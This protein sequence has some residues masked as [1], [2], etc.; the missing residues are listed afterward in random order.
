VLI[1]L[2]NVKISLQGKRRW[3][4]ME[5]HYNFFKEISRVNKLKPN[6]GRNLIHKRLSRVIIF[7]CIS[8]L[9]TVTAYLQAEELEKGK[10]VEKVVCLNDA[11]QS[12]ALFLP[13]S[14]TPEKKWPILYAF[15]PSA[16]GRVP[17]ELFKDAGEKYG[18]IVV[19]SYNSKNGPWEDNF[20][21]IKALWL[22][23]HI[24]YKIDD[25]RIYTTGFSGGARVACGFSFMLKKPVSGVIA[26]SGGLP[27]WLKADQIS[28]SLFFGTAGVRDFNYLELKELDE[29]FD[30]LN[31]IHRIEIFDG[32]HNWPP[33][34]LCIEAIEWM[35]LQAMKSGQLEKDEGLVDDLFRKN[36]EKARLYESSNSLYQAA[37]AYEAIVNDFN[38]LRD[39]SE[40]EKKVIQLKN[41]PEFKHYLEKEK[42]TREKE[43]NLSQQLKKNWGML[44]AVLDSPRER[45]RVIKNFR[46]DYL[47][48][49]AQDKNDIFESAM[50]HRLLGEFSMNAYMEGMR[51]LQG[52]EYAKAIVY[53]KIVIKTSFENPVVLY[54]LACAY[55]LNKEKKNAIKT[56]KKA[57][58]KGFTDIEM[59]EK[60]RDFDS[61][62]DE[63][64]FK[65]I[66]EGLKQ[67]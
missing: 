14:Y 65:V 22:D 20:Q 48:K 59:I 30:S 5:K 6:N 51:F 21:A 58:E 43:R 62:R 67:K 46:I 9:L 10:I 42:E 60:D 40:L 64:E 2:G 50:A 66:I 28:P 29:T 26:S 12:Y 7:L 19:G 35:E 17:V 38:G 16:R 8:L 37:V 13:S 57:V 18:Y 11:G 32:E 3:S 36:L 56:L 53:L 24:R 47:V 41:T 1:L 52:K 15:D 45:R 54:N 61:I 55:S 34:G 4:R 63:D 27:S 39:V 25:G 23:T 31:V 49:K 33:E 44:Q